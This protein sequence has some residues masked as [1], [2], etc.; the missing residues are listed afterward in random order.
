MP[1]TPINV[2]QEDKTFAAL[3][4]LWILSLV[5][6]LLK[7]DRDFVQFHA[8][9]GFLLFVGEVIITLIGMIP[10]LGWIVAFV[11]WIAAVILSVAGIIAALGG[12][13]WDMPYLGEYARKL[14]F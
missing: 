1:N 12:R 2:S 5:P 7:R 14:N 4:Y 8:R 6:L 3:S 13:Y 11:G 9:Q 10:L